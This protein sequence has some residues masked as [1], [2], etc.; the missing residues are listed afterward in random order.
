[1]KSIELHSRLAV[2]IGFN[3][4]TKLSENVAGDFDHILVHRLFG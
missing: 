3:E 4:V 1:M 2:W